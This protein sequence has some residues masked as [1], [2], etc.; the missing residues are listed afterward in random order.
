[1]ETHVDS[2]VTLATPSTQNLPRVILIEDLCKSTEV[3]GKGAYVHQVRV[4]P[5]WMDLI[6]LFLRE[7]ILPSD[8]LEV[9]KIWWKARCF[10]MSEDQKFYKLFSRPYLLYIHSEALELLL[11][12]LHGGIYGSHTGGRFL[13]HRVVT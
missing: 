1:M 2:L 13:S 7:D 6:V 3:R 10:W 5:S 8:K 12:E 11:E 4:E 9:D